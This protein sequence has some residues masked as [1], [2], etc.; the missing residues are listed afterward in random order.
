VSVETMKPG[1]VVVLSTS[2]PIS[3]EQADV[4]KQRLCDR[5][6]WLK[7]ED[8]VVLAGAQMSVIRPPISS[9]PREFR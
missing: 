8:V 2:E 7:P 9:P 1:D 5:M 4:I 6:P 3:A